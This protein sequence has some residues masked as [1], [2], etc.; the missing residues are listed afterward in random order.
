M[1]VSQVKAREVLVEPRLPLRSYK[2]VLLRSAVILSYNSLPQNGGKVL[3]GRS[4]L[5]R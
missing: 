5:P 3:L 2:D 4:K 1:F